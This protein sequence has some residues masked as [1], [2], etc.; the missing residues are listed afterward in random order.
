MSMKC[1]HW[2]TEP[3]NGRDHYYW[4][5]DGDEAGFLCDDCAAKAGF[6]PM[7]GSFVAGSNDDL[8]MMDYGMC[9]ECLSELDEYLS[10]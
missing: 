8:A 1:K 4:Y 7:C 9:S 3:I 10:E 2:E 6:C 5:P